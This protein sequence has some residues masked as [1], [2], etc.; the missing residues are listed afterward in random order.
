MLLLQYK[1]VTQQVHN[2]G[3]VAGLIKTKNSL[4]LPLAKEYLLSSPPR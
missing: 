3:F 2:Q 1:G 4:T